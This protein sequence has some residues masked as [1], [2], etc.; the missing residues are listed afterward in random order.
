MEKTTINL[1][2]L[3]HKANF[4]RSGGGST[5]MDHLIEG[6]RPFYYLWI[7][8][9]GGMDIFLFDDP[10]NPETAKLFRYNKNQIHSGVDLESDLPTFVGTEAV[11]VLEEYAR[12]YA[13]KLP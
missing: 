3:A 7:I 8:R 1:E 10:S 9:D 5:S 2:H 12:E 4:D 13:A 11:G 6:P